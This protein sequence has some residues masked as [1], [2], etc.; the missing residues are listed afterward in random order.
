MLF[1][2]RG[3][4]TTEISVIFPSSLSRSDF[5]FSAKISVS[6]VLK[7]SWQVNPIYWYL[8]GHLE[9]DVGPLTRLYLHRTSLGETHTYIRV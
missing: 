6:Q 5:L 3:S 2:Y 4:E 8:L 7:L 1:L 9:C